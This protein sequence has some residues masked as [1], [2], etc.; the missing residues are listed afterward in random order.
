[1]S[2]GLDNRLLKFVIFRHMDKYVERIF[3]HEIRTKARTRA[4]PMPEPPLSDSYVKGR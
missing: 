3:E 4:F 1:M 2:D